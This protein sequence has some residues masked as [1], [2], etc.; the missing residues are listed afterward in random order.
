WTFSALAL[1]A[2]ATSAWKEA[3]HH[4]GLLGKRF[5]ERLQGLDH[6]LDQIEETIENLA[7]S[8]GIDTN[9]IF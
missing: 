2:K 6:F 4:L 1:P 8:Q 5:R 3:C 7:L 9:E